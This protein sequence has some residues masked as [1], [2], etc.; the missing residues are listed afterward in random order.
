MH[1]QSERRARLQAGDL[2]EATI[3]VERN[4]TPITA[5]RNGLDTRCRSGFEERQ[6]S[7]PVVR[8]SVRQAEPTALEPVLS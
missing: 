2:D 7:I 5:V 8:G 4:G 1:V 3:R 6:H